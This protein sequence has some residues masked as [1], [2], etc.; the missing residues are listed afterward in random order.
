MNNFVK[1]PLVLGIVGIICT[2]ALS[3][4]YEVTKDKIA[5]NKNKVAI[6]LMS[7]MMDDV[8]NAESVLEKY[9]KDKASQRGITNMYEVSDSNGVSAY[10]YMV[11]TMGQNAFTILVVL[12]SEE[13]TV[14]GVN[15]VSH[16]ET[17]SYG[18]AVLADPN[19]VSQ[20]TN[21]SFD[22]LF[23]DV[24]GVAGST[25]TCNGVVLGVDNAISF[26]REE[27]FKETIVNDGVELNNKERKTLSLPEGYTM[28]D[29]T[30]EF[31]STLK[32][33]VSSTM[34]KDIIEVNVKPDVEYT[35]ILNYVDIKDGSGNLKGHA[36]VVEG[37]YNCEVD[38]GNRA[39]QKHKFVLMFDEQGNNTKVVF[40][41]SS[42]S[43]VADGKEPIGSLS[44]VSENFD[45]KTMSQLNE[46]LSNDGV[47]KVAGST[48]TTNMTIIN[49]S[50]VVDAHNRAFGN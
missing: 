18:G 24:D 2:G 50:V 39:W 13:S 16:S 44:W 35:K 9:N 7:T 47:D 38:E 20:F 40:V 22:A 41:S 3:V 32:G 30:E 23:T 14:V 28:V 11:D 36:Y 4:V 10:G 17:P 8:K 29:K 27:V 42:D 15:V 25:K 6:E 34:Y 45:G 5:Y 19:Y 48:F 33:K 12:D 46:I 21:I 37:Q 49:V 26:H 43:L 31:K 1:F